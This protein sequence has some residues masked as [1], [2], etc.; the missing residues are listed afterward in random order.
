MYLIGHLVGVDM[1]AETT[2]VIGSD[3]CTIELKGC[4]VKLHI[5][6]D[7]LPAGCQKC[8]LRIGASLSGQFKFPPNCELVSGVY[9]I[10]CPMKLTKN[11]TLEVQH[12]CTQ[13]DKLT[14][15]QA[16]NTKEPLAPY[17][18]Q[19]QK[20]GKFPEGT[21]QASIELG[22]HGSIELPSFSLLGI[23]TWCTSIVSLHS[24]IAK[25]YRSLTETRNKW[26]IYFT[27]KPDLDLEEEV[28]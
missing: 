9:W 19:I 11:M 12:C 17:L 20:G 3:A 27:I 15:V 14:F 4:G 21:T 23:V 6:Q 16:D 10:H 18:F 1:I 26:I 5:P 7:S 22:T 2:F 28:G 8:T 25:V 24:Y 13:T